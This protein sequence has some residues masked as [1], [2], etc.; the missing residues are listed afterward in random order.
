VLRIQRVTVW[1]VAHRLATLIE[2]C[3]GSVPARRKDRYRTTVKYNDLI[4]ADSELAR[5]RNE[6]VVV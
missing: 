6:P 2:V 5:M 1:S 4:T 3:C